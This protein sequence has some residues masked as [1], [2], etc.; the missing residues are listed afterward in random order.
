MT[1]P[2]TDGDGF[3]RQ[4]LLER[5]YLQRQG[6]EFAR[7]YPRVAGR[8]KLEE[9]DHPDPHVERLRQ[10]FAFLT[11]RVQRKLD[12]ELPEL[13][14]GLLAVLFPHLACPVPSM[15]IVEAELD[16]AQSIP[17]QGVRVPR[18]ASFLSKPVNG[19]PLRFRSGAEVR[20]W[21]IRVAE[22][23]VEP[24]S[25]E[26][27]QRHPKALL[28]LRLVLEATGEHPFG[29]L[30]IPALTFHL[31]GAQRVAQEVYEAL[32]S[33]LASVRVRAGPKRSFELPSESLRAVGFDETEALLPYPRRSFL[34]YRLLQEY[35]A[36]PARFLFFE[37]SG[38]ERM[39]G[40][41]QRRIEISFLLEKDLGPEA[42]GQGAD[43]FGLGCI[44]LVNPF[45]ARADPIVLQP[46]TS[47][48]DV[49]ADAHRPLDL[50]VYA[51][52]RVVGIST[53]T[54]ET[55]R[56]EPFYSLR[57]G[58]Q[59]EGP[60]VYWH[61]IRKQSRRA[62]DAGTDVRLALVDLDLEHTAPVDQ[63]LH[64]ELLCTN[65]DLPARS[66]EWRQADDFRIEGVNGVRSVRCIHG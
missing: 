34:G 65:R 8:L 29:A 2:G 47:E 56:Y 14:Q 38:L 35:F 44:P 58:D 45:D 59:A 25:Q 64:V 54:G 50:E 20:L 43:G 27:L 18:G 61:A 52:Q 19:E 42:R 57:H 23:S 28:D 37:L 12:D 49:V 62:G 7:S 21:P 10:S 15:A 48:F 16:P 13:A 39:R 40:W 53:R 55:F 41:N 32:G 17:T 63:T 1:D 3:V 31:K 6:A 36:F 46:H 4:Y 30:E 5:D 9:E 51:V 24:P 66:R 33:S 26:D 22:A 11:A 60:A